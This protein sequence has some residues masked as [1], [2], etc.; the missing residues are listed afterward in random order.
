MKLAEHIKIYRRGMAALWRLSRDETVFRFL[1]AVVEAVTPYVPIWFSARLIDAIAA[2]RPA[3]TLALYAGLTVG[4]SFALGLLAAWFQKRRGVGNVAFG[5]NL[6]FSYSRKAM[7]MSYASIED[8]DVA[9]RRE[10]VDRE[11]TMGY[12][13]HTLRESTKNA[14]LYLTQIAASVSLTASFFALGSVAVWMKL[15]LAAGVAAAA[16]WQMALFFLSARQ[17]RKLMSRVLDVNLHVGKLNE[18]TGDY[19]YGKDIRLY[20]MGEGLVQKELELSLSWTRAFNRVHLR[21]GLLDTLGKAADFALRFG[22]Y[23]V[24][25]YAALRGE[26]SVGSIA[27]YVS[28]VTL[29]LSAATG[30][31]TSVTQLAVNNQYLQ[32]WFSFFD[33]PND[34]YRGTLTVEK[35]DDNEYFVEFRDVSF[36]YPHTDAWA[37]RHVN[38]KFKVGQ[39]LAVVGV[40]GSGKTTFIKLLT[41]LYDPTEGVILLNGVDIRKYDY[42][43]YMS[44]FSVVFQDFR[45]FSVSLGQNVAASTEFDR[46]RVEDCLKRAGL[47]ERESAMPRGLD[48]PLYKDFDKDGV[49]ISGG[50]AQKIALARAL[51]KDAPF[52][53]LDE[54]TAALDPVSEYQVYSRFNAI[55]GDKTA[56]YISHR[57]ASCRF[58]DKIAVFDAG[59]IVQTGSH[60]EL[61]A[62]EDGKYH[63]LWTAQ[64]QYYTKEKE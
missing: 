62:D 30:I 2:G 17:V 22:V 25:I 60:E 35:R 14:I 44:L 11:T 59:R 41:R 63:A 5:D 52:I 45:L 27:Q 40:N 6:A 37:L 48:T 43:E 15:T 36:Q 20:D 29:L 56:V 16:A 58:C 53:I 46:A 23:L 55:A 42:D 8:R 28:C 9:L 13:F 64:A 47:E 3:G 49:E 1:G 32:R 19:A 18:L 38:L 33:I 34:M 21:S 10:R 51:Y 54:P 50:E 39:R 61:L 57:L 24:L 7:E 26:V 31:V 12:N 4:L